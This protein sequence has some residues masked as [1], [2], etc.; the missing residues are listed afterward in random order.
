MQLLCGSVGLVPGETAGCLVTGTG[1]G[2]GTLTEFSCS[3]LMWEFNSSV[4]FSH[5][6][7]LSPVTSP[8]KK[9]IRELKL[10]NVEVCK[11]IFPNNFEKIF[12]VPFF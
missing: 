2:G 3:F 11:G 10:K 5:S 9:K 7:D 12:Y 8:V 1:A 6:L 4:V